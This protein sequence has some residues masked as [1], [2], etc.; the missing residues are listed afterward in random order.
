MP[1]DVDIEGIDTDVNQSTGILLQILAAVAAGHKIIAVH[2][3][4]YGCLLYTSPSPRDMIPD[5]V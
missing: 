3:H 5:R 1:A 2:A 4:D